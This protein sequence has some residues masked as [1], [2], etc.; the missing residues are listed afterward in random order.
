MA[1]GTSVFPSRNRPRIESI[2]QPMT[3]PARLKLTYQ[4]VK[5]KA[6]VAGRTAML[7]ATWSAGDV[8]A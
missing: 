2:G 4:S 8:S 5:A 7:T 3:A 1:R 6:R